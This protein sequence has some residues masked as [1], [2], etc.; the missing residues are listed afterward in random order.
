MSACD[1]QKYASTSSEGQGP[2][3]NEDMENIIS[4]AIKLDSK[5]SKIK[6]LRGSI[7]PQRNSRVAVHKFMSKER[8]KYSI[9]KIEKK[10]Q[11]CEVLKIHYSSQFYLV[12]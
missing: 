5:C 1:R 11:V 8:R 10:Q 12:A 3:I 6:I 9:K 2:N 4:I 7:T